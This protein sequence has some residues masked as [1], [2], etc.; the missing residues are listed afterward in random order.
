MAV[1]SIPIS[2]LIAAAICGT[3]TGTALYFL[4]KFLR[5]GYRKDKSIKTGKE[6]SQD[7]E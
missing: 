7:E 6:E 5:N 1:Q 4:S 3:L 2:H